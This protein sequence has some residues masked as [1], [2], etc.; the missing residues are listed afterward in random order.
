MANLLISCKSQGL[1]FQQLKDFFD[2]ADGAYKKEE[3]IS[4]ENNF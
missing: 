2:I 3:L 4:M 1:Y